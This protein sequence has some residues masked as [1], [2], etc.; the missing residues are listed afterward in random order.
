MYLDEI[1]NKRR[2]WEIS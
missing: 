1:W 2:N